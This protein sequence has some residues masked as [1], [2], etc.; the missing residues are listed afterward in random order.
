MV[1]N[2]QYERGGLAATSHRAGD[3]VAAL[4]RRWYCLG[5]NRSW[6]LKPELFES[7]VEAGVKF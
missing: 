3:N 1:Q 5:L 2:G 6:S 4:E 7:F